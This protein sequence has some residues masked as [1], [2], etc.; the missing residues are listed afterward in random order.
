MAFQISG[1]VQFLIR[2]AAQNSRPYSE[3]HALG[4]RLRTF[5]QARKAVA[6]PIFTADTMVDEKQAIAIVFPLDSEQPRVI[7]SPIRFLPGS[8]EVVALRNIGTG[9]RSNLA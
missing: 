5:P 3:A 7:C 1:C 2:I 9:V 8:I 6:A 4:S